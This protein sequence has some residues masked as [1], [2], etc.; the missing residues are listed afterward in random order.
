MKHDKKKG[1]D[2]PRL[3]KTGNFYKEGALPW[4]VQVPGVPGYREGWETVAKFI[5][6]ASA[7]DFGK[8]FPSARAAYREVVIGV[9]MGDLLGGD[10][11]VA[12]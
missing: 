10:N 11:W 6:E 5:D 2:A 4:S 3:V 8:R 7:W 9:R 1:Q 12:P